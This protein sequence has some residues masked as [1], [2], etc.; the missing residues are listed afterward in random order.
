MAKGGPAHPPGPS[1]NKNTAPT[2]APSA[3][4]KGKNPATAATAAAAAAREEE[5][6]RL[7]PPPDLSPRSAEAQA[8]GAELDAA[9]RA[10][11]REED[12]RLSVEAVRADQDTYA[13]RTTLGLRSG[14]RIGLPER[15]AALPADLPTPE[16]LALCSD[17]GRAA[18]SA[19]VLA[20]EEAKAAAVSSGA[21]GEAL[22]AHC[23]VIDATKQVAVCKAIARA[24]PADPL[25]VERLAAAEELLIEAHEGARLTAARDNAEGSRRTSIAESARKIAEERVRQLELEASRREKPPQVSFAPLKSR[26]AAHVQQQLAEPEP[27]VCGYDHCRS[28][29]GLSC[30]KHKTDFERFDALNALG[31]TEDEGARDFLHRSCYECGTQLITSD[32]DVVFCHHCPHTVCGGPCASKGNF[33]GPDDCAFQC[34]NCARHRRGGKIPATDFSPLKPSVS[35]SSLKAQAKADRETKRTAAATTVSALEL[36][37]SV[38]MD[39]TKAF[40][41]ELVAAQVLQ[42][43]LAS[44]G[45]PSAYQGHAL[46]PSP[47][48]RQKGGREPEKA[49]SPTRK[50]EFTG[51]DLVS[52]RKDDGQDPPSSS[53]G[54]SQAALLRRVIKDTFK[55]SE[56]H[57]G[58]ALV[59]AVLKDPR[60]IPMAEAQ[61]KE[62]ESLTQG[63]RL[64]CDAQKRALKQQHNKDYPF[65][66]LSVDAALSKSTAGLAF[67]Q[68]MT[69][70]LR[71]DPFVSNRN[72]GTASIYERPDSNDEKTISSVK[73]YLNYLGAQENLGEGRYDQSSRLGLFNLIP[74]CDTFELIHLLGDLIED[75]K[76]ASKALNGDFPA[77]VSEQE[78]QV[79][80]NLVR[81][82]LL[83]LTD[84]RGLTS[85]AYHKLDPLR[86]QQAIAYLDDPARNR[87]H[88]R[89]ASGGASA[90]SSS[91]SDGS[92]PPYSLA[93]RSA[94]R[95]TTD[96][97]NNCLDDRNLP[98][99]KCRHNFRTCRTHPSSERQL[100]AARTRDI[101]RASKSKDENAALRLEIQSLKRAAEKSASSSSDKKSKK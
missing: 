21:T 52:P 66:A 24:L 15:A 18:V 9:D 10:A 82:K 74:T 51:G 62:E 42:D 70:E 30:P 83:H 55:A 43:N 58:P 12:E 87:D 79:V 94:L 89:Y 13:A 28:D 63:A 81:A 14:N 46:R 50:I 53:T 16:Q 29:Q 75:C 95:G 92:G 68:M 7:R 71:L 99:S 2:A 96:Y 35:L 64:K 56:T 4:S 38:S 90:K 80:I 44:P 86:Y 23:A 1:T 91:A 49:D 100:E 73:R 31:N 47:L 101:K 27:S 60:L 69:S 3:A 32:S 88:N 98:L 22:A 67:T 65:G 39:Q 57:R 40:A 33:F 93:G 34:V 6:A 25:S 76:A 78:S 36:R 61:K 20:A 17:E 72:L 11:G 54:E 41:D 5:E 85:S 59:A 48:A 37:Y 97:C 19:A 45:S 84:S 77:I 26:S 8:L